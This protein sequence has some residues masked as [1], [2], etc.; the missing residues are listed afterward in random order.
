MSTCHQAHNIPWNTILELLKKVP[1]NSPHE[2]VGG[3][4]CYDLHELVFIT[5]ESGDVF[6]KVKHFAAKMHSAIKEFS[7]TE[8]AKYLDKDIDQISELYGKESCNEW[9]K[10]GGI[11]KYSGWESE[12]YGYYKLDSLKELFIQE[13]IPSL[14]HLA[15]KG[16]PIENYRHVTYSN[17][18]HYGLGRLKEDSLTLYL[19]LNILLAT[20]TLR[21]P[22][23]WHA[24]WRRFLVREILTGYDGNRMHLHMYGGYFEENPNFEDLDG[25]QKLLK[26]L[27]RMLYIY[28]MVLAERGIDFSWEDEVLRCVG[29][30]FVD[31][32]CLWDQHICKMEENKTKK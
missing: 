24:Q 21:E 4:V 1:I 20:G 14:L 13:K 10:E 7:K 12:E 19:H 27:F 28:D 16:F 22:D 5:D 2:Y 23:K 29:S 17:F 9:L 31:K 6:R 32:Y 30:Y 15:R 3:K 25:L 26:Q 8:R 11:Q 18:F